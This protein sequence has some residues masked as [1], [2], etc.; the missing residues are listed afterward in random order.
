MANGFDWEGLTAKPIELLTTD[1]KL[2]V[3]IGETRD[4][5]KQAKDTATALSTFCDEQYKRNRFFNRASLTVMIA[6]PSILTALIVL[7]TVITNHIGK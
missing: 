5:K 4:T 7:Y 2:I 6:V 1:E 3:L